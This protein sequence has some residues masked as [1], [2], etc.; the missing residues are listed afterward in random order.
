MPKTTCTFTCP[1]CGQSATAVVDAPAVDWTVEPLGDYVVEA[2]DEVECDRCGAAFEARVQNSPAF[3]AVTLLGH[4]EVEVEATDAPFDDEV[5]YDS[6]WLN[7]TGP[8]NALTVLQAAI[9]EIED[10]LADAQ[11]YGLRRRLI[12]RLA[13]GYAVTAL[14]VFLGDALQN[15][16]EHSATAQLALAKALKDL[17]AISVSAVLANPSAGLDA[18]R[19]YLQ[20]LIYHNLSKIH[21]ICAQAFGVRVLTG[22]DRD[23]RLLKAVN[24]RHDLVHRNGK[25]K[26]GD[27]V[28]ID[29]GEL[30]EL[31]ID[32]AAFADEFYAALTAATSSPAAPSWR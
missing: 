18:L 21:G 30:E 23:A 4:E 1:A 27:L 28:A 8:E 24:K 25:T 15:T 26:S 13:Y 16:I 7:T 6:D 12:E 5:P 22:G 10:L 19:Q 29:Q 2:D 32:I 9:H 14:E 20:S 3:C 17:P 31:F 11:S